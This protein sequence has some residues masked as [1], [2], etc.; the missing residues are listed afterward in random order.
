MGF[1]TWSLGVWT[2]MK[3]SN[4]VMAQMQM[5]TEKSLTVLRTTLGK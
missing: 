1:V 2:P 3:A 5:K 4:A